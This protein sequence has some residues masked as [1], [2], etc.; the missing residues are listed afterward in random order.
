MILAANICAGGTGIS[1]KLLP[2]CGYRGTFIPP[3]LPT[4]VAFVFKDRRNDIERHWV[5]LI[6]EYASMDGWLY[7]GGLLQGCVPLFA[8]RSGLL[9][10]PL[11]ALVALCQSPLI[12]SRQTH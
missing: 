8:N 9:R 10:R 3:E 2:E 6:W 7:N 4:S 1:A 5:V 12:C 11:S